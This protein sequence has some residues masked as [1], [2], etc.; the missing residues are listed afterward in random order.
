MASMV[1]DVPAELPAVKAVAEEVDVLAL[2][3][4]DRVSSLNGVSTPFGKVIL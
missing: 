1:C 3:G 4:L 2:Y